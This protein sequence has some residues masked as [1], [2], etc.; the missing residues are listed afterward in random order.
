MFARIFNAFEEGFV[1]VLLITMTLL[2]FAEVIFR[3]IFNTGFLW[4]E[5]VTLT[6]GAW[7]VLFGMSYGVKVGGHIGVDAFVKKLP[8][9]AK[10]LSAIIAI[11]VCLAYCCMFL[12]GGAIYIS[13]MYSVGITMED[14]HVPQAI[15]NLLN[16]E[17]AWD[18]YKIDL[19]DPLMPL[20]VSQSIII[21]GF[22]LLFI[23]FFQLLI[24]V[25]QG[26]TD[27]FK[28]A[29]EAQESM[30]LAQTDESTVQ[31][32]ATQKQDKE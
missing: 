21:L 1:S 19:E 27:G 16:E 2:V 8:P 14:V 25:I 9:H 20:W 6:L 7:F 24:K 3:F 31:D 5:E 10:K 22:A 30:H 13:K 4:M 23:R 15:V 17:T 12:Y 28:F 26:K 18:T 11:I 29:D 32:S